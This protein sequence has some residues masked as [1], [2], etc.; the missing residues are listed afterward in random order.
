[1]RSDI[2]AT[3]GECQ[4]HFKWQHFKGHV[5]D[6]HFSAGTN[7]QKSIV[8]LLLNSLY[9]G[10]VEPTFEKFSNPRSQLCSQSREYIVCGKLTGE[11]T[12]EKKRRKEEGGKKNFT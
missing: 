12:R 9:K 6:L 3:A 5:H 4:G 11:T 1:V 7:S 10:P 8:S 2:E